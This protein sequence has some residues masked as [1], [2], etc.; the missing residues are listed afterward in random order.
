MSIAVCDS[1]PITHLWQ[2]QQWATFAALDELHAARQVI[3]EVRS[4]VPMEEFAAYAGFSLQVHEIDQVEVG[5]TRDTLTDGSKL[6][7]ADIA[8]I[9]LA[10]RLMPALVLTDDLTLRRT[11]ESL[12]LTPMGSVGLVLRAYATNHLTRSQLQQA[13]DGLFVQSTLYLSP[14]FR[15]FVQR[16]V[17]KMLREPK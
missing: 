12:G 6:Q 14:V 7:D 16:E 17:E 2:I 9:V 11:L 5:Q 13:I 4:H 8:T 10:K 3:D 15:T 1:G